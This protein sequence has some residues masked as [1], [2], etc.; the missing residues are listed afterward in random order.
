MAGKTSHKRS[1]N[2][3]ST[4]ER[5]VTAALDLIVKNGGCRGVN[6]RQIA[7]RAGCAHTNVYNYFDTL[8]DLFW[9][10]VVQAIECQL[11]D[12]ARH[13]R[14]PAAARD[15]L[16]TFVAA[17]VA[18]TQAHPGH[19]RLSWLEPLDGP[20]PPQVLDRYAQMKQY[21][22]QHVCQRLA[23]LHSTV[24]RTQA[25]QLVHGYFHGELCKL[26][27]RQAFL[28]QSA[29]AR[30]RIVANTLALIDLVANVAPR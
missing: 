16:R 17:Q 22:G 6:L 19:Y 5:L 10:A 12:L 21:W 11:A 1:P 23:A 27:G 4:R 24:D 9:A 8:E 2:D 15:P 7:A 14:S 20:T 26:I 29:D 30:E 13:L 3:P 25:V 28:P 18:F